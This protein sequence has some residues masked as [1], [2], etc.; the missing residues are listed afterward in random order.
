MGYKVSG[1]IEKKKRYSSLLNSA[2]KRK[3][4]VNITKYEYDSIIET[5]CAYCG[6]SLCDN[7]GSG[8]DRVD[9]SKGYNFENVVG[10]CKI[11]N[12]AKHTMMPDEFFLWII[13]VYNRLTMFSEYYGKNANSLNEHQKNTNIFKN[14]KQ[15]RNSEVIFLESGK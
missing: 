10:C 5:G 8:L 14:S 2:K 7:K 11:C 12:I 4:S 1:R 15:N 13:K 3:I 9:P 6:D